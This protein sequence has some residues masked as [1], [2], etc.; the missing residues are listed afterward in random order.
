MIVVEGWTFDKPKTKDAI[1]ALGAIG[2]D[3]K[4][5]VVLGHGDENA[6]KSF[7]NIPTVHCLSVGELNTYDVLDSDV[8]VFTSET[9]PGSRDS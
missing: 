6:W 4:V 9:L 2:A 5:L 3:G 1:T 7:R 8:V